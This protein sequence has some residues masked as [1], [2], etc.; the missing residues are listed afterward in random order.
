MLMDGLIQAPMPTSGRSLP[1]SP[2]NLSSLT[3]SSF[4]SYL[5]EAQSFAYGMTVTSTADSGGGLP[6]LGVFAHEKVYTVFWI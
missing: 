1:Q 5:N 2:A 6:D 3:S 4:R